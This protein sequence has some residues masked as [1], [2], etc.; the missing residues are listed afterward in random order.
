M[1]LFKIPGNAAQFG[2]ASSPPHLKSPQRMAGLVAL[3]YTR[4]NG[5]GNLSTAHLETGLAR[6][7]CQWSPAMAQA[8]A[9]RT[10]HPQEVG[11][12]GGPTHA[13]AQS[14]CA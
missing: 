2:K 8:A 3:W 11:L 12:W 13:A 9:L 7:P 14:V 10:M 1:F 5:G 4:L 6:H